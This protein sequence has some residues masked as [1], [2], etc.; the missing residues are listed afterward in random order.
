VKTPKIRVRQGSNMVRGVP[1]G[2]LRH[3]GVGLYR[4]TPR[5]PSLTLV[6]QSGCQNPLVGVAYELRA[7]VQTVC[8]WCDMTYAKMYV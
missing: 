8:K 2:A 7:Q 5:V 1:Y 3:L 4:A 6:G